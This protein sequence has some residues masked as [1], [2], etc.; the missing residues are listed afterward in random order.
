MEQKST[1][2]D[3]SGGDN[4]STSSKARTS[5]SQAS[6]VSQGKGIKN[7]KGS[8]RPSSKKKEDDMI[9]TIDLTDPEDLIRKMEMIDF[10]EEE[11]EELMKQA[12]E[13]NKMLKKELQKNEFESLRQSFSRAVTISTATGERTSGL[14]SLPPVDK[15]GKTHLAS[16]NFEKKVCFCY[17]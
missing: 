15:D 6:G 4:A 2:T 14:M 3:L 12:M 5:P 13:V 10:T 8:Q 7:G 1:K 16:L 11:T 17:I 9:I